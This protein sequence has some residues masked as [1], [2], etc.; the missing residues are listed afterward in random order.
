MQSRRGSSEKV[1]DKRRE[2]AYP[3]QQKDIE[4]GQAWVRRAGGLGFE[5]QNIERDIAYAFCTT[6]YARVGGSRAPLR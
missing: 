2:K 6:L 5:E 1:K 3:V 4:G